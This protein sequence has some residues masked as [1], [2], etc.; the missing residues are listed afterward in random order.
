MY[1]YKRASVQDAAKVCLNDIQSGH[2]MLHTCMMCTLYIYIYIY[3]SIYIFI[4]NLYIVWSRMLDKA[5]GRCIVGIWIL[6]MG[7]SETEE[8]M[9]SSGT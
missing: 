9:S 2:F 7:S 5:P 4:K 1:L 6:S 3:I 8:C